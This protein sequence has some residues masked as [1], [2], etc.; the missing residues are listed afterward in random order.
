MRRLKKNFLKYKCAKDSA[1]F[2]KI[3]E[4]ENETNFVGFSAR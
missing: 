1:L 3:Y 2:P 4:A